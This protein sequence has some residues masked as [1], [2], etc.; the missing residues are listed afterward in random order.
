MS[1]LA[2]AALAA[3]ALSG[4]SACGGGVASPVRTAAAPLPTGSA[5]PC[6]ARSGLAL[7]AGWPAEVPLPPGFIITRTERR[8]GARLIAYGRVPGNF[9]AVVSFFDAR[10][11]VAG[12]VQ[13]NG[14]VDRFD[15]ESDFAGRTAGG[16]W[17][18][19]LSP[20]CPHQA[21]VTVLVLPGRP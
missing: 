14:Q 16:R 18:T 21:G 3:L 10:L 17:T 2:R 15:A 8:S 20:E 7:L 9:H 6:S 4:A 12:F 11:P 13:R 5:F 19:G 1:R